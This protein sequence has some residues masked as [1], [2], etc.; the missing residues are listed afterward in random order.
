MI[1]SGLYLDYAHLVEKYVILE[2]DRLQV[3]CEE[4]FFKDNSIFKH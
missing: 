2:V 4:S 3:Y 1:A